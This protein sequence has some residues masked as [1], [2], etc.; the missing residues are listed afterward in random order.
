MS[1]RFA[2][3][4]KINVE[5]LR[6]LVA[7][8]SDF[9]GRSPWD[10]ACDTDVVG[11]ADPITGESSI[12]CILGNA[13]EVFGAVFYRRPAGLRW[14][15]DVLDDSENAFS[16]QAID[17]IDALKVEFVPKR[18]M[19]KEDLALLKTAEFSPAGRGAVWPQFRS[20]EPGWLPWFINQSEA[21]QLLAN[22]PRLAGFASL[23][24]SQPDLFEGRAP[25]EIPFVPHP[26]PPRPL[27]ADDLDWR[28]LVASPEPH[29]SF[30]PRPDLL[31]RLQALS[32]DPN[33][34]YEYACSLTSGSVMQNGRPCY[35]RVSLLVER[36]GLVLGVEL[37][38]AT[39]SF[40]VSAGDG[41]AQGLLKN[42]RLPKQLLVPGSE[43]QTILQPLC[44]SL[45]IQL[46]PSS[47]LPTLERAMTSLLQFMS[48]GS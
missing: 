16:L 12:A 36:R 33:A 5:T 25:R 30:Q 24:K 27:T 23:L 47:R 28:L 42:G 18:E 3:A 41:L 20:I 6:A 26:L 21:E 8:A 37:S 19:L 46:K 9:A 34:S 40:A 14:M 38:L 11:I 2:P 48:Q 29:V 35:S 22:L 13:R 31:A 1:A 4:P 17:S 45:G 32:R 44:D 43:F 10:H 7:A 15:L 39:E